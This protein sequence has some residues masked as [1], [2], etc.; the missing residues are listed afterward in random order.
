MTRYVDL[1]LA[2]SLPAPSSVQSCL[3]KLCLLLNRSFG[4]LQPDIA[5]I[6]MR[7][8]KGS[9]KR[10]PQKAFYP[11]SHV[12][13]LGLYTAPI[14]GHVYARSQPSISRSGSR[15]ANISSVSD[16]DLPST[17]YSS[18]A[19]LSSSS[20]SNGLALTA[21]EILPAA[22]GSGNDI[23][24]EIFDESRERLLHEQSNPQLFPLNE[25]A[26]TLRIESQQDDVRSAFLSS[27]SLGSL[28]CVGPSSPSPYAAT[29]SP[30]GHPEYV[31]SSH[32]PGLDSKSVNNLGLEGVPDREP[33][34]NSAYHV[35]Q[36]HHFGFNAH[37]PPIPDKPPGLGFSPPLTVPSPPT[38]PSEIFLDVEPARPVPSTP[39][40]IP[41][42]ALH[43]QGYARNVTKSPRNIPPPNRVPQANDHGLLTPVKTPR[44][45]GR[46]VRL[47]N[48]EVQQASPQPSP[49]DVG[50]AN[51]KVQQ[52]P[53]KAPPPSPM[54]LAMQFAPAVDNNAR[55]SNGRGAKP[56]VPWLTPPVQDYL[57]PY[58]YLAPQAE[59]IPVVY[60]SGREATALA[61]LAEN[62]RL[63]EQ[64]SLTAVKNV[65]GHHVNPAEFISKGSFG[66][67]MKAHH[68]RYGMVALKALSKRRYSRDLDL[69]NSLKLEFEA[70]RLISGGRTD[71]NVRHLASMYHSWDDE[72]FVY[73]AMPLY[74]C[75]L[76]DH[77]FR[78]KNNRLPE[79]DILFYSLNLISAL[80]AL[81]TLGIVHHDIKPE[82]IFMT[83]KGDLAL[84]D[85]GLCALGSS[86]MKR[87]DGAPWGTL[88]YI[89]PEILFDRDHHS[90]FD[91]AI[92]VWA[93]GI[94]LMEMMLDYEDAMAFVLRLADF[95]RMTYQGNLNEIK[96]QQSAYIE[97]VRKTL[98]NKQQR[99]IIKQML[100]SEPQDRV[101]ISHLLQYTDYLGDVEETLPGLRPYILPIQN[102][103]SPLQTALEDP[104]EG[105]QKQ[106]V[107]T[108]TLEKQTRTQLLSVDAI[109]AYKF[110]FLR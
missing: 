61:K 28:A 74:P 40:Q 57:S 58:K 85:Y 8:L 94:V 106:P 31:Q 104:C 19:T 80:G 38:I 97:E 45:L 26:A 12:P 24:P 76:H 73:F 52:M 75:T 56:Q 64:Q 84:G 66:R 103:N 33:A 95:A 68:S 43:D 69:Y 16:D 42:L 22:S 46:Q 7:Y 30:S 60:D 62:P 91:P 70:L 2:P 92:D 47:G 9:Y 37:R 82:N 98:S 99:Q 101:P 49:R 21:S 88:G 96:D 4:G 93:A 109:M 5:D 41:A 36:N 14:F 90:Q 27:D 53:A 48:A 86:R 35:D 63:R 44:W 100:D 25:L 18:S 81:K 55:P 15:R 50:F 54:G 17:Y 77:L 10:Y 72:H 13:P 110:S 59:A 89:P 83:E 102:V 71:V 1:V 67:V 105:G 23:E 29:Y 3:L 6:L 11:A 87:K 39:H 51:F 108:T 79:N 32:Y 107:A 78:N 20:S 65:D 34:V